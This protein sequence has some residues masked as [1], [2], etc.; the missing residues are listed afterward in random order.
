MLVLFFYR[1]SANLLYYGATLMITVLF[2]YNKHCGMCSSECMSACL[3][4]V[5]VEIFEW[6]NFWK[7]SAVSNS[8]NIIF[9]MEQGFS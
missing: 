4:T 9:E 1:F 2:Q 3:N 7:K 5:Y 6:L 8:E